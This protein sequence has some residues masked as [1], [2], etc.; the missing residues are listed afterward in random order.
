M[1]I[2]CTH[3]L[4]NGELFSGQ[5]IEKEKMTI[6][7]FSTF[8]TTKAILGSATD[9]LSEIFTHDEHCRSGDSGLLGR[10]LL[11]NLYNHIKLNRKV[12]F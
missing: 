1:N 9:K 2:L 8:E 5:H 3:H 7:L 12:S 10:F 4:L 6:T 11:D